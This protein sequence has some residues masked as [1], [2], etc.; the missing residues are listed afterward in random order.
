[1]ALDNCRDVISQAL[2]RELTKR[3]EG[4]ISRRAQAL[5]RKIDLAGGSPEAADA[6]FKDMAAQSKLRVGIRQMEQAVTYRRTQDLHDW[7]MA[8]HAQVKHAG[9]VVRG[10]F[11]GSLYNFEGAKDSVA[12][13]AQHESNS[14]TAALDADL[15]RS[16]L[17]K[18]AYSGG[19]DTNIARAQWAIRNGQDPGKFGPNAAKVA[20]VLDKHNELM[21]ADQNAAGMYVPKAND[22]L[23]RRTHDPYLVSKAGGNDFGSAA[24]RDAWV[25]DVT[26]R[27]DWEHSFDG[28]YAAAMAPER[29][30]V[31]DSLWGQFSSGKH[32][33]FQGATNEPW[34]AREIRFRSADDELW[35]SQKYGS[36]HSV[37]DNVR[38]G[39]Q[40]EGRWLGV[41]KRLGPRPEETLKNW[42]DLMTRVL[43]DDPVENK[44]FNT[45]FDSEM[46]NTWKLLTGA[47]SHPGDNYAARALANV[48]TVTNTAALGL[49]IFAVPGDLALRAAIA[50][51]TGTSTFAKGLLTSSIKQWIPS[52]LSKAERMDLAAEFGLRVEG[53][54]MPLDPADTGQLSRGVAH[55]YQAVMKLSGH[56]PWTNKIR[57]N[58]LVADGFSDWADRAKA[59]SELRPAKQAAFQQFGIDEKAWN[60]LRKFAGTDTTGGK[61]AF[62]PF[63]VANAPLEKF[64][65]MAGKAATD[66]DLRDARTRLADSYRNLMGER[67]DRATSSPSIAN[68]ANMWL[69]KTQAGTAMGELQRGMLQ[70]KGFV[71]NYMRNHLGQELVGNRTEYRSMPALIADMVRGKNTGGAY[72]L[73]RLVAAGMAI[74][75]ATNALKTIAQGKTPTDPFGYVSGK[76]LQEQPYFNAA[77]DAFARQSFGLYSDF[78]VRGR[79]DQTMWERMA[80]TLQGPEADV[81]GNVA[82]AIYK[83]AHSLMA[84]D[85]DTQQRQVEGAARQLFGTTWRNAPFTNLFWSK[86]ILDYYVLNNISEML[87][88]GY[89]DR[90]NKAAAKKGQTYLMG[91]AGPQTSNGQ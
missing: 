65:G 42:R 81:A 82:G 91:G 60:T 22:R 36:G 18:Y 59:F 24:S 23:F 32:L 21:R 74:G 66:E 56:A 78:L 68:Q 72:R 76:P 41:M 83:G 3:E 1:M 35:Y 71:F 15:E 77:L 16:G 57:L 75:Y 61:K 79:T 64:R 44:R 12:A 40:A 14:R 13:L 28:D 10:F 89:Q 8:A 54:H 26:P 38:S 90:L 55:T 52:G 33:T 30:K 17:F 45:Q 48:R 2:G 62:S 39:L 53:L 47:A 4:L 27:I 73:G 25:K 7:G 69:G 50:A 9:E 34:R 70:L 63:E 6:V 37:T 5:K 20:Q 80:D 31:L 49:S 29:A 43:N 88:P 19:D 86:G 67:A 46:G 51:R 84:A 11:R 87:N 85:P 58:S